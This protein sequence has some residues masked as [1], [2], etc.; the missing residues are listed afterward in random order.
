M[1]EKRCAYRVNTRTVTGLQ[2]LG[3]AAFGKRINVTVVG[4]AATEVTKFIAV[5]HVPLPYYDILASYYAF[6][7]IW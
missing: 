1:R 7:S 5:S 4:T 3:R 2:F 6:L